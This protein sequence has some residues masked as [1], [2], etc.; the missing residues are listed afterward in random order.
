MLTTWQHWFASDAI[1]I[2]I[3]APLV[4]GLTAAV[5][6]PPP[7]SELVEGTA[8]LATLAVLTAISNAAA[9]GILGDRGAS[10]A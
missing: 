2:V 7:R 4:I 8:A 1:G 3:V 10:R 6:Q 9:A 5:R